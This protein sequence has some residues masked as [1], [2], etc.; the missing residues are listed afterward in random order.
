VVAAWCGADSAGWSVGELSSLMRTSLLTA[1]DRSHR[2]LGEGL[3]VERVSSPADGRV[4]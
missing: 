1:A 3:P 2:L 4:S